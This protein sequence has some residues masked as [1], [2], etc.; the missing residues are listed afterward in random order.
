MFI[1]SQGAIDSIA[2]RPQ[3]SCRFGDIPIGL[4]NGSFYEPKFGLLQIQ[5][6]VGGQSIG[7]GRCCRGIF[8]RNEPLGA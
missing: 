3:Q 4:G 1:L 8:L 6:Q 2:I 5:R 7:C